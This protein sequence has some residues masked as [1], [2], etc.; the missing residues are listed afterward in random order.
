MEDDNRCG[1]YWYQATAGR[2]R[3]AIKESCRSSGC[4]Q[5]TKC[6]V[7]E[8]QRLAGAA[9]HEKQRAARAEHDENGLQLVCTN[10]FMP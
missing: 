2:L 8:D 6:K 1:G 4:F 5:E 3:K 9:T 10:K 7:L